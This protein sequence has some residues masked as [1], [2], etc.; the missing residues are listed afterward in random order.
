MPYAILR[1]V[2]KKSGSV[3]AC[4]AH[5]ERKKEAYKSNPDIMADR[6]SLNYHI[7][8]PKQTYRRDIQRL[9]D[10]AGCKTR[11]DS[12]VMV[13][14]L[15]TASPEF[16][17]TLPPDEQR[18][19]F[20]RAF[21]FMADKI[22]IEN[23]VAAVVHMDER[24]AHM[25]LCFCP[26]TPERKLSAKA[27]LGNQAQLSKWQTDYHNAMS[28]RWRSLERGVSSMETGRRHIPLSLFKQAERLDKQVGEIEAALAR[29]NFLNAK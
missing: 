19:Y 13:E 23:I 10:E 20:S 8:Q 11:K 7:I 26:I 24:T 1:F 25:H 27:I 6:Q 4:Y 5:N 17:N 9:I 3:T 22:G 2:K 18:E 21:D 28:A 12:T 29:I 14:T 16:M 15:I